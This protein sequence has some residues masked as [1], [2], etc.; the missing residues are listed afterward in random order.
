[1]SSNQA[2][3]ARLTTLP[4]LK[5]HTQENRHIAQQDTLTYLSARGNARKLGCKAFKVISPD[6]RL[7]FVQLVQILLHASLLYPR[8]NRV[9][10]IDTLLRQ[11]S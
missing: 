9:P 2:H 8:K 7:A 10:S 3:V 1:M 5:H 4:C 6:V 11:V